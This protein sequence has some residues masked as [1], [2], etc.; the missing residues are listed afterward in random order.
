MEGKTDLR[1]TAFPEGPS[2]SLSAMGEGWQ[3]REKVAW[4][5]SYLV[6]SGALTGRTFFLRASIQLRRMPEVIA[7]RVKT[8]SFVY[9]SEVMEV[10]QHCV[11]LLAPSSL[12]PTPL[13]THSHA[14]WTVFKRLTTASKTLG[15]RWMGGSR[16]IPF[17]EKTS[18]KP[19]PSKGKRNF[20]GTFGQV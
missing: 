2:Q 8:A 5:N 13:S 9:N 7:D 14:W 18:M 3:E 6:T 10:H 20:A 16:N 1:T 19:S 4:G 17:A 12:S 11:G 15:A